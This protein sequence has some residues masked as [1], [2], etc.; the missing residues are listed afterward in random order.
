MVTY[1]RTEKDGHND[2]T[3]TLHATA[4]EAKASEASSTLEWLKS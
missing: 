2:P 1:A 4:C 3:L